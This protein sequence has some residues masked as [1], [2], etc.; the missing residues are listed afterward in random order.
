MGG[1]RLIQQ[2]GEIM[3]YPYSMRFLDTSGVTPVTIDFSPLYGWT[4]E[5]SRRRSTNI[6]VNGK[7]FSNEWG[8]KRRWT[9]PIDH[10]SLTDRNQIVTWWEDMDFFYF[11][12]DYVNASDTRY[13]I[14]IIN[15]A[16]PMRAR[17]G[18]WRNYFKGELIVYEK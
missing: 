1:A 10:I 17:P 8:S 6:S 9:L 12:P 13:N 7:I 2:A 16:C 18:G 11:Y 5:Q 15:E 3:T 14:Y 4:E